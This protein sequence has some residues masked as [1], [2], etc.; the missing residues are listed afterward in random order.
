MDPG[1]VVVTEEEV[2]GEVA[3]EEVE[4]GVEGQERGATRE[5]AARE[6]VGWVGVG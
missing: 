1:R 2:W 3:R 5:A 4:R 6:T